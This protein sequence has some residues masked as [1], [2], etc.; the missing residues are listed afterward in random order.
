M[1]V[2]FLLLFLCSSTKGPPRADKKGFLSTQDVWSKGITLLQENMEDKIHGKKAAKLK[3]GPLCL[4]VGRRMLAQVRAVEKFAVEQLNTHD[5]KYK[6]K[7]NHNK[8]QFKIHQK[9]RKYFA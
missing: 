9:L 6:L 4:A 8:N 5:G 1:W 7:K 2:R 3:I